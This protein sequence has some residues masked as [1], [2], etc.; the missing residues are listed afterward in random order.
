MVGVGTAGIQAIEGFL[1][2]IPCGSF[3]LKGSPVTEALGARDGCGE[4]SGRMQQSPCPQKLGILLSS[5]AKG[6]GSM[7]GTNAQTQQRDTLLSVGPTGKA[8]GTK[9]GWNE[10]RLRSCG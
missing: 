9:E 10:G 1:G 3:T 6:E 2:K 5:G 4:G 7:M 8:L